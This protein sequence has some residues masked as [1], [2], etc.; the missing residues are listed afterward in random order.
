MYRHELE[1]DLQ[2]LSD[3]VKL[4]RGSLPRRQD[5]CMLKSRYELTGTDWSAAAGA[6]LCFTVHVFC[7]LLPCVW[8]QAVEHTP[9][10]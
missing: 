5:V 3:D 7:D 1:T 4:L 8:H 2:S 9:D 6:A 10:C